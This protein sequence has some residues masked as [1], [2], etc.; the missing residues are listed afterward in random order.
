M[1][2]NY[3]EIEYLDA[4]VKVLQ[5]LSESDNQFNKKLE[6]IRKLEKKKIIWKEA[7]VLSKLW[8]CIKFKNCKYAP[9]VYYKVINYDS[10]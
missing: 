2:T 9:E 6:Y 10:K 5:Y 7:N 8:Y 4:K 1:E 3:I